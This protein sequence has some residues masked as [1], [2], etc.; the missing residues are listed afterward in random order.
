MAYGLDDILDSSRV[1]ELLVQFRSLTGLHSGIVDAKG[2]LR[3]SSGTPDTCLQRLKKHKKN[4]FSCI[5]L[6]P[7]KALLNLPESGHSF[8]EAGHGLYYGLHPIH[9][10]GV[11]AGALYVCRFRL[12]PPA[13]SPEPSKPDP[14]LA[15]I[16]VISAEK[17]KQTMAFFSNLVS[18]LT[19]MG[20]SRTELADRQAELGQERRRFQ[21]L[22]Q[23]SGDPIVLLDT[24]RVILDLNTAAERQ[25]GL[26]RSEAVGRHAK[27]LHISPER[28][29]E[30]G[31]LAYTTMEKQ[32]C[33]RGEWPLRKA[34]GDPFIGE[35]TIA[36]LA[37]PEGRT[38]GYVSI[39]RDVSN[40]KR[41][42]ESLALAKE[43]AEK[44]SQSKSLFLANMSHEIRTPLSGV[45]SMLQLVREETMSPE[46]TE[47]LDAALSAGHSL[48]TVVGDVI[49]L[50]RVE[51]GHVE[52]NS[53]PLDPAALAKDV[54]DAF[55]PQA[56][57]KGVSLETEATGLDT[58]V[59]GDEGRIRQV[60]FNLVNNALKHTDSGHVLLH[61][62]LLPLP[63][64]GV[65]LQFCVEDSGEGIPEDQQGQVFRIFVRATGGKTQRQGSGL[66]LAIVKNLV[67]LMRGE[68]HLES[69][70]DSGT[71]ICLSLPLSIAPADRVR[72]APTNRYRPAPLPPEPGTRSVNRILLAEDNRVNQIAVSRFL[73]RRG[74][75][76]ACVGDGSEAV[77]AVQQGDFGLV[78]MDIQM[79]GMDGEEAAR[80]I[81]GLDKGRLLP[82]VALTAYAMKGDRERF[83]EQGMNDY[84]PKPVDLNL[85]ADTVAQWIGRS[86]KPEAPTETSS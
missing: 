48:L 17:M 82:I 12:Q 86:T 37:G 1:Q 25:F 24:D 18:L 62:R 28:A 9:L 59:M 33:W 83:L 31:R 5:A 3:A 84:L 46:M 13:P 21:A 49:D 40:R 34:N 14:D 2:V 11:L 85:L 26:L 4:D 55:R 10:H 67:E 54:L 50:S 44:A 32:G 51:S 68:V 22:F 60:L 43:N 73:E 15:G 29:D 41:L 58:M 36:E 81:R 69:A 23:A 30:F 65:R 7:E 8:V 63:G 42:E 47:H 56:R 80:L 61:S 53:E 74:Y 6:E 78:L 38:L 66:G 71:T 16:P 64:D 72:P 45:L 52:L 76:V 79:P 75:E 20:L 27:F 57:H 77:E 39:L 19:D 70:P 35:V